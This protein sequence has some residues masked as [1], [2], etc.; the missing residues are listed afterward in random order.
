MKHIQ[1]LRTLKRVHFSGELTLSDSFGAKWIFYLF[2]GNIVYARGGKHSVRR[3]H[4][5]VRLYHPDAISSQMTWSEDLSKTSASFM[6]GWEYGLLLTWLEQE[7]ISILQAK[8]IVFYSLVEI[9]FDIAQTTDVVEQIKLDTSFSQPAILLDVEHVVIGFSKVW[10]FCQG[11]NLTTMSLNQ[12]LRIKDADKF[13]N[14]KFAQFYKAYVTLLNGKRT[15]RDIAVKINQDSVSVASKFLPLIHL[16]WVE[17]IDVPDFRA[18][19]YNRSA[20]IKGDLIA[21][22]DD[23]LMV[24]Q[25]M[26]KLLTSAGYEYLGI[27]D[28]MRALG[29]LMARKPEL[30]FL[31]LVMPNASG[32]EICKQMRK[33]SYF[34][35]VPIVILTGNDGLTNRIRSNFVGASDFLGKPLNAEKV[36]SVIRKHLRKGAA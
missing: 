9:L 22:V 17:L 24:H 35:D 21:C 20:P 19:I 29:I 28:A 18:P 6:F 34:Q 4:R 3:W 36:L 33:L 27:S 1:F 31:D 23:S 12:A 26:E 13:N 7:R 14:R 32:Y 16:G 10:K 2:Q 30:L 5:A 25:V 15:I 11:K 8:K